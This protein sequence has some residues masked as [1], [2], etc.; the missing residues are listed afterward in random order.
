[1]PRTVTANPASGRTVTGRGRT[2]RTVTAN[3]DNDPPTPTAPPTETPVDTTPD[4]FS[5]A[6]LTGQAR[7]ATVMSETVIIA[8]IAAAAA[9]TITGGEY[10]LDGSTWTSAA[11][12][13]SNGGTLRLRLTTS[14]SYLTATS[15][16]VT[17]GGVSATFTARTL[18][19]TP[20]APEGAVSLGDL[21]RAG[22]RVEAAAAGD[23]ASIV[24]GNGAGHFEVSGTEVVVSAAGQGA[25][26]GSYTLGLSLTPSGTRTLEVAIAANTYSVNTDTEFGTVLALSAT[27][28]AGKTISLRPGSYPTVRSVSSK[29]YSPPLTITAHDQDDMPVLGGFSFVVVSGITF[30]HVELYR[31]LSGVETRN[32]GLVRLAGNNGVGCTDLTWT[33]CELHSTPLTTNELTLSGIVT[34]GTV[35]H[36]RITITDCEFYHLSRGINLRIQDDFLVE[37]N[38]YRDSYQNFVKLSGGPHRAYIRWNTLENLSANYLDAGTPHSGSFSMDPGTGNRPWD[39][40]EVI[41]NRTTLAPGA[42]G[43]AGVKFNDPPSEDYYRNVKVKGNA[44]MG[45]ANICVEMSG[46]NG[47]E[48]IGNTLISKRELESPDNPGIYIRASKNLVIA[49][50]VYSYF[51]DVLV[52]GVSTNTNITR[53]NNFMAAAPETTTGANAY[54]AIFAGPDF[55]GATTIAELMSNYALKAGG[56]LDTASPKI[57]A[58]GSGYVDFTAR[59][60]DEAME[61]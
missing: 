47:G 8:G 36:S 29:V 40:V 51:K 1:M 24:S 48:I 12:S 50:N 30:D 4:A 58:I 55:D 23:V 46:C 61:P 44:I 18:A 52:D 9:V 21:T 35:P 42:S 25:L 49:N 14:A 3:P 33:N 6:E 37:R 22:V 54:E 59:T 11:G 17:V 56:P 57:G 43:F 60:L 19:E 7:S 39:T 27:T 26:T 16:T 53:T 32:T 45:D 13:I 5:F 28:L 41:G 2:Q 15:A 38:T 31:L 10:T 20:A 34:S